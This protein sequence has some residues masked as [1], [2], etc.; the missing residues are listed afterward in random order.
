[1]QRMSFYPFYTSKKNTN[2]YFALVGLGSNISSEKAC[3]KKL[4]RL[5]MLDKRIK[6]LAS[7]S[8]FITRPFG[9]EAQKDFTN[10][11]LFIQSFLHARFL[12]K[13][14]LYYEFKFKRQRSFKNAPRTLDLDLLYF[15]KKTKNDHFCTL[16]HPGVNERISVIL[17]L[18]E[19][20][21]RQNRGT[22]HS[23]LHS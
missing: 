14:L 10:A 12:L 20:L 22:T 3:F 2:K 18:G 6:I 7:S 4:F 8:L 9:F 21:E 5:L 11:V 19:L 13:I 15:S 16:P 17:P 23:Y 1:M